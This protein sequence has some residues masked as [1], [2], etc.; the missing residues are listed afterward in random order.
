MKFDYNQDFDTKCDPL[1]PQK[2]TSKFER[3]QI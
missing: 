2:Q 3:A 1:K